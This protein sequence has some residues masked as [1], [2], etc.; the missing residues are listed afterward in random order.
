[1]PPRAA[2]FVEHQ[3]GLPP[4]TISRIVV[5]AYQGP[6]AAPGR[7]AVLLYSP[8]SGDMRSASTTLLENLASEGFV[9]AAID[10][11]HEADV[12]EFPAGHL[13]KGS[14]VDTGR[15]SNTRELAVRVADARF[16]VNELGAISQHGLLRNRLDLSAIGMFG[17][18]LGGA[19]AAATMLIDT[20]I[21]AGADLD[22]SLYGPV[23]SEGLAR[24]FMF[25]GSSLPRPDFPVDPSMRSFYAHLRGPRVGLQLAAG[26]HQ[27]FTDLAQFKVQLP[28]PSAALIGN[29]GTINPILA[30][31]TVTSY[32]KAFFG[33]YLS[34][35]PA[36]LLAGTAGPGLKLIGV[37]QHRT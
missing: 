5:H 33:R 12:V 28:P 8:G 25:V 31:R 3:D 24:P 21:K 14:F 2:R 37:K 35:R 29:V 17:H 22:G 20:R 11:T 13:V 23:A 19:T 10:H 36:P 18:S 7:H 16:V 26:A 15:A 4:G 1:M 9:V 6:P 30:E 32:L 34:Q 27:T